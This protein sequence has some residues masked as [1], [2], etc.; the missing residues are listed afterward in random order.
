MT[1]TYTVERSVHIDGP[2]QEVYDRIVDLHRWES[3]SPYEELDPNMSKTY[4]GAES[5]VGAAYAWSG[6]MKAGTGS[7]EITE[8]TVP[9]RIVLDLAFTKPFK[10]GSEVT[11]A[12]AEADGGS[13][14]TWTTSGPTNWFTKILSVFSTPDK[15]MD[16][17]MGKAFEQGL[18]SLKAEVEAA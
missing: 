4:S 11:F 9:E 18:A 7:M 8:A 15:V 13:D 12:I 1:Q 6:N 3:W 5:G 10:S 17:M 14:V 16:K 2:R